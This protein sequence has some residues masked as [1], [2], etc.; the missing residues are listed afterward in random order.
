MAW[1]QTSHPAGFLGDPMETCWKCQASFP[2]PAVA[3][4]GLRAFWGQNMVGC[5]GR[6][7]PFIPQCQARVE[8]L[9]GP[10]YALMLPSQTSLPFPKST[11]GE[12]S[13]KNSKCG[14]HA[15]WVGTRVGWAVA[16][17]FPLHPSWLTPRALHLA[18][19]LPCISPTRPTASPTPTPTPNPPGPAAEPGSQGLGNIPRLCSAESR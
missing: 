6:P 7:A 5:V 14:R 17:N 15:G 3:G 13:W 2:S 19:P 10:G 1:Q 12:I 9:L 4:R 11:A 8:S 16:V 18:V